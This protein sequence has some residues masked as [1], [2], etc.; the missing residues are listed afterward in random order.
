L[1]QVGGHDSSVPSYASALPSAEQMDSVC[2]EP[3]DTI[4]TPHFDTPAI[5]LH[6]ELKH[7]SFF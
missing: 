3:P 4:T 1:S 6:A 5:Q 2:A 7:I